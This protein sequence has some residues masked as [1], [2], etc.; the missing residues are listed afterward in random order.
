MEMK[1]FGFTFDQ[2][3]WMIGNLG[4]NQTLSDEELYALLTERGMPEEEARFAVSCREQLL[5]Q[6][7]SEVKHALEY[8]SEMHR[9][10]E[11]A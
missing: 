4:A 3:V 5:A 8:A 1:A 9:M 2:M 7:P 6:A 10:G 11:A